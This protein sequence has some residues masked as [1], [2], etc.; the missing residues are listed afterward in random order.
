ML[1]K[2]GF[3]KTF[4]V[5]SFDLEGLKSMLIQDKPHIQAQEIRS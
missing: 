4:I 3:K 5:F 1:Q 2:A